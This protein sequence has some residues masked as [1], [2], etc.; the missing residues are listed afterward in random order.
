MGSQEKRERDQYT[1]EEVKAYV[2]DPDRLLIRDGKNGRRRESDPSQRIEPWSFSQDPVADI[3]QRRLQR[4]KS[5]TEL[6]QRNSAHRKQNEYL[7]SQDQK[8]RSS[9]SHSRE[10]RIN[11][12]RRSSPK[13]RSRG[14]PKSEEVRRFRKRQSEAQWSS[15]SAPDTVGLPD[16]PA[17]TPES[18]QP[19]R[20]RKFRKHNHSRERSRPVERTTRSCENG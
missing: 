1:Y 16:L 10:R 19:Q 12:S 2:D 18:A 5:R 15:N 4:S 11:S 8:R 14:E 7:R 3:R 20:R 9:R 6:K 17:P 13:R